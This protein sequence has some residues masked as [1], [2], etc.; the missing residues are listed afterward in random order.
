M[1]KFF[2]Y[3]ALFIGLFC[4]ETSFITSLPEPLSYIPLVLAASV[5]IIQYRGSWIG[6]C[7]LAAYGLL[8]DLFGITSFKPQLILYL[9]VGLVIWQLSKH[10]FTNRSLYGILGSG[11]V[12]YILIT[13][14]EISIFLYRGY[15]L[16]SELPLVDIANYYMFKLILFVL[17]LFIFFQGSHVFQKQKNI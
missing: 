4:F 6:V 3:V 8:L 9:L 13:L 10:I 11:L 5:F 12:A 2:F 15:F 7:W 14:T 1:A 16:G 17:V